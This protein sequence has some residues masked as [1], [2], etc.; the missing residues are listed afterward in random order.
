[1][2]VARKPTIGQEFESLEQVWRFWCEYGK[3]SG[4][5]VRKQYFNKQKVDGV[6]TGC[7]YVCCKEGHQQEDKRKLQV[8]KHQPET[9]TECLA[10]ISLSL[11]NNNK[12]VIREFVEEH[13]HP[14]QLPETMHM[15][16]SHRNITEVQTHEI[17]LP[18]AFGLRQKAS[19]QLMTTLAEHRANVG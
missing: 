16:A 9:R 15:L 8:T 11:T 6:I 1:M 4:F 12:Y 5:G 14:L 18:E 17:D 3:L 10:R 2:D 13:N 19:S 7:R